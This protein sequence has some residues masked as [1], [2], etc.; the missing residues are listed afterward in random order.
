MRETIWIRNSAAILAVAAAGLRLAFNYLKLFNFGLVG[1]VGLFGGSRLKSWQAFVIP[2]GLMIGTDLVL[3]LA[4]GSSDYGLL[5][6]SRPWVYGSYL[7]YVLIGRYLIGESRNPAIIGGAAVLGSV[8]FFLITNFGAWLE[9]ILGYSQDPAGL[10]NCYLMGL[11]FFGNTLVGDLVSTGALFAL[12][13]FVR[14]DELPSL[15]NRAARKL[16]TVSDR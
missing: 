12:Y 3:A 13:E 6:P 7:V 5:H 10:L 11:P 2:L 1:G 9:P 16:D 15:S 4:H 14:G 8:Q